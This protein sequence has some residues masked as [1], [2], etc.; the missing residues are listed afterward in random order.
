MLIAIENGAHYEY[1]DIVQLEPVLSNESKNAWYKQDRLCTPE[2]SI[3][4][5]HQ[6]EI[7]FA[8]A[9]LFNCY[10]SEYKVSNQGK[11]SK[12]VSLFKKAD[13]HDIDNYRPIYLEFVV[14]CRERQRSE[15]SFKEQLLRRT[16][17][18]G[19]IAG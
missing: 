16:T 9:R 18:A 4:G 1:S 5:S 13:L 15:Q 12:T 14:C 3:T 6:S 8:L 19:V 10:L 17:D 7:R 2:E 11:T